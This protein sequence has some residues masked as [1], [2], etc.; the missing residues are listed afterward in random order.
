MKTFSTK[1]FHNLLWCLCLKFSVSAYDD[2]LFFD[3]LFKKNNL[4]VVNRPVRHSRP[5]QLAW[6][7]LPDVW[8][9]LS[10]HN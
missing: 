10:G 3:F 1:N 7:F 8:L 5:L 6:I 4:F 9:S 2:N